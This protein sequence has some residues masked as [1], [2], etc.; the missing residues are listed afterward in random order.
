M[1]EIM[2][3]FSM[4]KFSTFRNLYTFCCQV[5]VCSMQYSKT[6][7]TCFKVEGNQSF[8]KEFAFELEK[9]IL[10]N[11]LLRQRWRMDFYGHVISSFTATTDNVEIGLILFLVKYIHSWFQNI[12][13]SKRRI[14]NYSSG[15]ITSKLQQDLTTGLTSWTMKIFFSSACYILKA[16]WVLYYL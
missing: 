16:S 7:G 4:L 14:V 8:F 15:P 2:Q 9:I 6:F 13:I 10:Q 1:R 11:V 12:P 5:Y 3:F